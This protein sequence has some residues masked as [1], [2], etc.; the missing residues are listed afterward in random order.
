MTHGFTN[1]NDFQIDTTDSFWAGLSAAQ[2]ANVAANATFLAGQVEA[3]FTTTTGWFGTDTSKF[4]TSHR[5]EVALDRADGKGAQNNGYGSVIEVDAQSNNS[6]NTAGPIVAMLWMAE[7]SEILMSLTSNWHA[8]DS[9]GEGLSHYCALQL[10]LNGHNNYY[11]SGGNQV[12][13]QNWLNGDG[14]TNENTV[15][16]N[17]ARSDWVNA[18]FTGGSVGSTHINGDADPVSYGCAL[19]F[20]YYLTVQLGFTINEVIAHYSGNLA[21]CYHA[22]TGDATDP[23]PGFLAILGHVFPAGQPASLTT[24]N[25]DNP[26][27]IAQVQFIAGKNTF[28]HDEAQDII[29][30]QGGLVSSAFWV[31]IDG[32]SQQAFEN[33][34]IEVGAFTGAF[35]DAVGVTNITPDPA[36][37]QF[38]NGVNPKS[39]GRIRIPFDLTLRS[40]FMGNFPASGTSGPLDLATTLTAANSGGAS[41]GGPFPATV[42]GSAATM[43]FELIAGAD[44]Y[45]TNLDPALG[46]QPYLSQDLRVFGAAPAIN[47]TPFP[48]GPAFATDSVAGAYNYLQAL[49]THLNGTAAF[50]NPAGTD[51]F[52]LL[53]GQ[54]GE[55]Q[56]DSSVAPFALRTVFPPVF[57]SN[58]NFAL[59]RVRLRGASGSSGAADSVRVFFRVFAS[60]SPDTDYAPG[61]TYASQPDVAG[62]P[63]TPLP[64]TGQST[65]P[66]FA[67]GNLGAETDYQAGGPNIATIT[68]PLGQH[69]VWQYFGCFLN[70][71]DPANIIAGQQVQAYLPG[72]HHCVVAQI[73]YDGAPIPAGASPMSWDQLAQRN[74]QFTVVDNPGPAATHRAPQTFDIRPSGAIGKPGGA[75]PGMPPDVL[76][77][78]WGAVPAGTTASVYWPAVA[79]ADVIALARTWGGAAGLSATDAST[80]TL[81]VEGGVSY[82]P[83]PEGTGQNFAGLLTLELPPGIRTGQE[84]EVLV[85]R[86]STRRTRP[87]P[88]PEQIQA[89][90][91][92]SAAPPSRGPDEPAPAP[93]P[94]T[95]TPEEV[96]LWQ[97]VVGSFVVRIPV[98]TGEAMLIPEAMTLAV[99]KWRLANI[100]PGS[101]WA[102]VLER[103]V[104]YCAARLDGIGG[105]STQVPPSLTWTPPLPAADGDDDD[106]DDRRHRRHHDHD[107]ECSCHRDV[108]LRLRLRTEIESL[109]VE[110]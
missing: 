86:L 110:S 85:R 26:F 14:T 33:L 4:G 74:L 17:A 97:Y 23:F 96:S 20:I 70:F 18:T 68:I 80:L 64:G 3:P 38:Q 52:S 76:M 75:G 63:G 103:Y 15:P 13:V 69:D 46:N 56:T 2:Q 67:T 22:V 21:S 10:F 101:R 105:D 35:A 94:V 7:W 84:F 88:P 100:S 83:V 54:S 37:P 50:T 77:I 61:S 90:G 98:S 16:P 42:A 51:P 6:G 78:D 53:P 34:G 91:S 1:T 41:G 28:G 106:C 25:P 47:A 102:P 29:N 89:T 32:L 11:N 60:Q 71:Y 5:Q 19:G 12:F 49:L 39:P 59:A 82:L 73:A 45:F 58:Y 57:V 108:T 81:T 8:N 62:D 92:G 44:P 24:A 65:L 107:D 36:G 104:K 31:Q 48:G 95:V 109:S 27:P 72:T 79:A 66:F 99:M 30:N 9:S 43:E 93:G 87:A 55:G 40:P